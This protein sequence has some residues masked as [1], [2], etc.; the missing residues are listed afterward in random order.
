MKKTTLCKKCLARGWLNLDTN[1]V[2][3]NSMT[4][5]CEKCGEKIE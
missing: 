4:L 3:I 1:K 2:I 5:N